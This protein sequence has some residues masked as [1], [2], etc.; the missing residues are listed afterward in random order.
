MPALNKD[1]LYG[2][3]EESLVGRQWREEIESKMIFMI[4][5]Y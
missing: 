1:I 2:K 3:D 4:L 5:R